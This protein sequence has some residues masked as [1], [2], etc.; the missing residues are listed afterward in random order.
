M[1]YHFYLCFLFITLFTI[2]CSEPSGSVKVQLKLLVD[3]TQPFTIVN[4]SE[5]VSCFY[6]QLNN[7]FH[8]QDAILDSIR[9]MP[10]DIPNET[11][12]RKA[13]RF[14]M[15]EI[16]YLPALDE[17]N[18]FHA[19]LTLLN[20]IGYGQCDDLS[21]MLVNIWKDLGY[22][23][24]V[25][26][27]G[28]HVV[29]EVKENNKWKM[30]DPSFQ[31]YYLNRDSIVASVEELS[32]E[33]DLITNPIEK[34]SVFKI[35]DLLKDCFESDEYKKFYDSYNYSEWMKNFYKTKH[36]NQVNNWFDK[37]YMFDSLKICLT[38][39]SKI[40]LPVC[41]NS[42]FFKETDW[43]GNEF[44]RSC[45]LEYTLV[46]NKHDVE[47]PLVHFTMDDV[48]ESIHNDDPVER[49]RIGKL[50]NAK[51]LD[52]I[53]YLCLLNIDEEQEETYVTLCSVDTFSVKVHVAK[54]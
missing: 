47:L 29:P 52:S 41:Y 17:G 28:G 46:G 50:I 15:R 48:G 4:E 20:S 34:L 12:A 30:Y 49:F 21:S 18:Q 16:Y 25:Y 5:S 43:F 6:I 36:D 26:E 37:T 42:H 31:V 13:W 39:K 1:K 22:D 38:P 54:K 19:P 40:N 8:T 23:A 11:L 10:D 14:V 45:F 7:G 2:S 32:S 27:L 44:S 3:K 33:V 35:N 51:G 24:R 9:K 53:K